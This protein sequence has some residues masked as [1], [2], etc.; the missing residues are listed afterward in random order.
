M[1]ASDSSKKVKVMSEDE[2]LVM[3][4]GVTLSE[5]QREKRR[6]DQARMVQRVEAGGERFCFVVRRKR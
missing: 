2:R 3:D 4:P 5:K 6:R 1:A